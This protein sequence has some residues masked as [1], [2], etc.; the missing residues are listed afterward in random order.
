MYVPGSDKQHFKLSFEPDNFDK[1]LEAYNQWTKQLIELDWPILFGYHPD[2]LWEPVQMDKGV[3][4]DQSLLEKRHEK[5]L[6]ES[7]ATPTP[8]TTTT[9]VGERISDDIPKSLN[10]VVRIGPSTVSHSTW[11]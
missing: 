6:L 1:A 3:L 4:E 7:F 5:K 8:A 10:E 2:D 9:K 11:E